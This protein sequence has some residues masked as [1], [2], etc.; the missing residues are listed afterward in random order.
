MSG[1]DVLLFVIILCALWS[2]AASVLI[3]RYLARHGEKV[4]FLL[5]RARFLQ[6]LSRYRALT[7]AEQGRPGGLFYHFVIPINTTLLLLVLWIVLK[8]GGA[9]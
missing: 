7:N 5:F 1:L 2:S 9:R 8:A 3:G 6:H 4:N